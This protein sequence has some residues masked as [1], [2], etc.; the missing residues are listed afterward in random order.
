MNWNIQVFHAHPCHF[1]DAQEDGAPIR[2]CGCTGIT[3][4]SNGGLSM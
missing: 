2:S 4:D 3:P 1:A